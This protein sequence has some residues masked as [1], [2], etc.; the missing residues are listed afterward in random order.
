MIMKTI[1][2]ISTLDLAAVIGGFSSPTEVQKA[3]AD[4]VK[5]GV[6]LCKAVAPPEK[7]PACLAFA[8]KDI[9]KTPN[10]AD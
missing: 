9:L 7:L 2:T 4:A 5:R 1:E 8:H 10:S 6:T 3:N